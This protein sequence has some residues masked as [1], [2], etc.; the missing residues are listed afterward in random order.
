[1]DDLRSVLG[2]LT[3]AR[4]PCTFRQTDLTRAVKAVVAAGVEIT[5]IEIDKT[6]KIVIVT[7]TAPADGPQGE[8][9]RELAA[10]EAR[11]DKD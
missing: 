11:H 5:R 7:A 4:A 1:M 10:F 9:D 3:M 6:G 2:W 8:L